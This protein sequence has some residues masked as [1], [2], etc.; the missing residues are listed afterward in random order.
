MLLKSRETQHDVPSPENV[1]LVYK[2]NA[3]VNVRNTIIHAEQLTPSNNQ[4]VIEAENDT[5]GQ[6]RPTSIS[7]MPK[8]V[9]ATGG[10]STTLVLTDGAKVMLT[11]NVDVSDGLVMGLEG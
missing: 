1:L 6:T 7:G 10:L 8:N 3:D 4:I 2:K 11:V 9:T 5:R